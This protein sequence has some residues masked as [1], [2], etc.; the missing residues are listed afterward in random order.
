MRAAIVLSIA[1]A[2]DAGEL[3][4]VP[5]TVQ[6]PTTLA[7]P[8]V[9]RDVP[10]VTPIVTREN[11]PIALDPV[12]C[13]GLRKTD[14]KPP[15]L[16]QVPVPPTDEPVRYCMWLRT[17]SVDDLEKVDAYC[18]RHEQDYQFV[19][20]GIGPLHVPYPPYPRARVRDAESPGPKLYFASVQT[21]QASLVPA[22]RR[23][24]KRECP[25][26]EG[27][28]SSDLC[29]DNTPLVVAFDGDRVA[30]TSGGR[31]AFQAGSLTM[32]DWPTATTPWIVLDRNDN[33]AIDNGS[34][35]FG[36]DTRLARG[37]T[38]VNGFA[39]LAELDANGDGRIDATDPAFSA[40]QL[41]A[42][43]DADQRS[44]MRELTPLAEKIV[45]ISLDHQIDVRCDARGNCEGERANLTWRDASGALRSGDVIDVYLP[46]R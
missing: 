43:H 27:N 2:C 19:C 45:S 6:E 37:G 10:P 21:W 44:G 28:P 3:P 15:S 13:Y 14:I 25:G 31:F 8:A 17:L 35:L 9:S 23:Y 16:D 30:Y 7:M 18:G 12:D 39:A 33:G 42:D 34:E 11:P 46:R 22:Q 24:V 32:T 36:S 5:T 29:G 38:A 1:C 41:W 26:G 40:L 20:G 4:E